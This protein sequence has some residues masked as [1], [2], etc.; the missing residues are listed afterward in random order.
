VPPF[1]QK[2]AT[3]APENPDP[4]NRRAD[5]LRGNRSHEI[6]EIT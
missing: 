2:C 4:G 5:I 3:T 1:A 6:A